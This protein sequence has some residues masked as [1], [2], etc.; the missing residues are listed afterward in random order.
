M[1]EGGSE[2]AEP[3]LQATMGKGWGGHG[4]PLEEEVACVTGGK[5][6]HGGVSGGR[7]EAGAWHAPGAQPEHLASL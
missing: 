3:L 2:G 1:Q 7:N 5:E 4:E 6:P